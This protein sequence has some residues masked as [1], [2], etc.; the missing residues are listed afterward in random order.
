[1]GKTHDEQFYEQYAKVKDLNVK[2]YD[3]IRKEIHSGC[4]EK[5]LYEKVVDTYLSRTDGKATYTGDYIS[6]LRT[7]DIEGPA[8][9]KV[10]ERGDTIIVDALCEVDG[11]HCDTTRSFFC[12]GP[13]E[14][15]KKAY[16][17]LCKLLE[18]GKELLRPGTVAGDIYR[19]VDRR[20]KEE[21]YE[22]G[23]VHHAGHGLGDS[24]CEDPHFIAESE[25][26]LEENMLVALEPGIYIA[27][28][29]GLRV[30]NN[31]RVTKDG[32]VDVF[33]YTTRLEDFII[34]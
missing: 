18:E 13:N 3:R 2:A 4:T 27:G 30:E 1:M 11:V 20:L 6:G 5:E 32:G 12:G 21:G 28:K 24:W 8:S 19:Y 31:Y 7:C 15:Q 26:V 34:A 14:E 29:F 33:G 22:S 23:L 10:I 17:T 9:D 16:F 25:T